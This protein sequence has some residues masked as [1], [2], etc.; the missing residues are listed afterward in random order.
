MIKRITFLVAFSLFISWGTQAKVS[1]VSINL[2]AFDLGE[3][4]SLRVNL[5]TDKR[6]LSRLSF[7]LAQQGQE[8]KLMAVNLNKF[9]LLLT[10]VDN[11]FDSDAELVVNEY[12]IDRWQ[13]IERLPVFAEG[14]DVAPSKAKIRAIQERMAKTGKPAKSQQAY[15]KKLQQKVMVKSA[16]NTVADKA[17]EEVKKAPV[18][19]AESVSH[20]KSGADIAGKVSTQASAV[21]TKA[22]C[23]LDYTGTET[24]WRIATRYGKEW[25]ANPYSALMAIY[26]ANPKAFN[27]GRVSSLRADVKLA[28]PND[29]AIEKNISSKQAKIRFDS[30]K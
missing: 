27:N 29:K 23:E 4:P 21:Y 10:G 22:G 19:K 20:S 14:I 25:Q 9:M 13:E 17:P 28:C 18:D 24:L 30:L 1:H 15:H 7:V 12:R 2:R 6:D 26:D 11:V 16:S 8:E 5:V 3:H